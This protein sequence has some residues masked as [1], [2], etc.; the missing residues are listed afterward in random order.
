MSDER[1]WLNISRY[2]F[3]KYIKEAEGLKLHMYKC[4]TGHLTI[5][6]GHNLETNPITP[7]AAQVILEDDIRAAEIPLIDFHPWV[8][9]LNDVRQEATLD[10][11][12]NMGP[13]T[14]A[15]FKSFL[16]FMQQGNYDAA[17]DELIDSLWYR[18]VGNRSKRIMRMIRTGTYDSTT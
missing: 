16:K 11:M 15:Q 4:P 10:L 12:F 14:F 3:E 1:R 2:R 5:G 6:Y 9:G 13:K 8:L 17:A 18:Q 7:R